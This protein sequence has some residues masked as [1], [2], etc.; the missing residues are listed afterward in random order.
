M[1]T[2]RFKRL[3]S[4]RYGRIVEAGVGD[5]E[6]IGD[7]VGAGWAVAATVV[8]PALHAPARMMPANHRFI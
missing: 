5:G 1:D 3:R 6:T 8:A 7:I 4:R 2:T